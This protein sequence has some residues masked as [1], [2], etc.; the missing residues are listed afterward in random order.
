MTLD[1][2][3]HPLTRARYSVGTLALGLIALGGLGAIACGGSSQPGTGQPGVTAVMDQPVTLQTTDAIC[4]GQRARVPSSG[5]VAR[6]FSAADTVGQRMPAPE[7][8]AYNMTGSELFAYFSFDPSLPSPLSTQAAR[9]LFSYAYVDFSL[10][11][12]ADIGGSLQLLSSSTLLALSDFERFEVEDGQLVWRLRRLSPEHYAKALTIYDTDPS[13]DPHPTDG[14]VTGD[15]VG[16]CRC[17]FSGPAITV[18]LDG[19]L[20]L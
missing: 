17:E 19:T 9:D 14:C 8:V 7:Y 11:Q 3:Q 5:A 2:T 4:T 10:K 13:N 18:T 1:L 16:M 12:P 20:P 15:I 6:A